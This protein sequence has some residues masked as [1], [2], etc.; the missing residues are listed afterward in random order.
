MYRRKEIAEQYHSVKHRRRRAASRR[1]GLAGGWNTADFVWQRRP[2]TIGGRRTAAGTPSTINLL[3]GE[4]QMGQ[5]ADTSQAGP[6][7]SR[8]GVPPATWRAGWQLTVP[9][10]PAKAQPIACSWAIRR[11]SWGLT[12]AGMEIRNC[13]GW[14]GRVPEHRWATMRLAG[15]CRARRATDLGRRTGLSPTPQVYYI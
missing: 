3:R 9:R 10:P 12:R 8:R 14:A 5:R 6:V 1:A 11:P 15:P 13:P 7:L 4:N 2:Q